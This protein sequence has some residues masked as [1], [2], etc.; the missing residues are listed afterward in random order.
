MLLAQIPVVDLQ[1][2]PLL[3]KAVQGLPD[4]GQLLLVQPPHAAPGLLLLLQLQQHVG[5]FTLQLLHPLDVVGE[6]VVEAPELVLLLQP[7]QA[8]RAGTGGGQ[9]GRRAASPAGGAAGSATGG[10]GGRRGGGGRGG[11]DGRGHDGGARGNSFT[12]PGTLLG[13]ALVAQPASPARNHS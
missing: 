13:T 3:G 5:A 1:L 4:V 7:G 8:G 12:E 2:G 6:A 9:A 11:T 10:G